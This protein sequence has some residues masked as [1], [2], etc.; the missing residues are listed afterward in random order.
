MFWGLTSSYMNCSVSA[1]FPTP[2]LPTMITL[3]R[4]RDVWF[5][6]FPDA[7]TPVYLSPQAHSSVLSALT[8][9]DWRQREG[10]PTWKQDGPGETVK[11][12]H[13]CQW[14]D[15]KRSEEKTSTSDKE[16]EETRVDNKGRTKRSVKG[17]GRNQVVR[18]GTRRGQGQEE[19]GVQKRN[20]KWQVGTKKRLRIKYCMYWTFEVIFVE[21]FSDS[22]RVTVKPTV[23]LKESVVLFIL[24]KF[25]FIKPFLFL[26]FTPVCFVICSV[27]IYFARF[28]LNE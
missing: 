25:I 9:N 21:M 18:E 13:E 10:R 2:P 23:D 6:F 24:S 16:P 22:P 26:R 7:I 12:E 15:K 19:A 1:D 4:T 28:Q 20:Q 27:L 11:K 5:L 17:T 14:R 3:W 8:T